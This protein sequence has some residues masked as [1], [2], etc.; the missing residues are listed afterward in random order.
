MDDELKK[1]LD[2]ER[3]ILQASL[4]D[5][6][7]IKRFFASLYAQGSS[8]FLV[9]DTD[10]L[11]N[12][13]SPAQVIL[14]G[15][16]PSS[17][18]IILEYSADDID[19]GLPKNN[20]I[21]QQR[22]NHFLADGDEQKHLFPI[23]KQ[24]VL[25]DTQ[26]VSELRV[27]REALGK[28]VKVDVVL[29]DKPM[30]GVNMMN[31]H[32]YHKERMEINPHFA[33]QIV[34]AAKNHDVIYAH[35][36][37]GHF[38][39]IH[40]IDEMVAKKL[41]DA[42]LKAKVVDIEITYEYQFPGIY[43]GAK[44]YENDRNPPKDIPDWVINVPPGS[45]IMKANCIVALPDDKKHEILKQLADIRQQAHSVEKGLDRE[46]FDIPEEK[47]EQLDQVAKTHGWQEK[48]GKRW[49]HMLGASFVLPRNI[50]HDANNWSLEESSDHVRELKMIC[51]D[52]YE[53]A[54]GQNDKE[55][56]D[57][58]RGFFDKLDKLGQTTQHTQ[59][60]LDAI[61]SIIPHSA[62]PE[63]PRYPSPFSSPH[64]H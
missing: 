17:A 32:K 37:N 33:E 38:K 51:A 14:E 24:Y 3:D 44:F 31:V 49:G 28:G 52:L 63:L 16:K 56:E 11:T 5:T 12:W 9:R 29:A 61:Y 1:V 43:A 40:D 6:S 10:H 41:S 25:N 58:M 55:M 36:G 30:P 48:D 54:K 4:I 46:L 20:A 50:V 18:A 53:Y 39:E 34:E 15:T 8:V 64:A 42:G 62:I 26:L 21:N 27:A 2:A 59:R 57:R 23:A 7:D 19:Q 60:E 47:R 13:G 22:V 45:D 35:V